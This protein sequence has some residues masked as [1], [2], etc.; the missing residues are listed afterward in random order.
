MPSSS[1]SSRDRCLTELTPAIIYIE[2]GNIITL[3]FNQDL[4]TVMAIG[5]VS[6]MTGDISNIDIMYPFLNGYTP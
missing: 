3:S 6:I 2:F 1:P 5:V 4:M